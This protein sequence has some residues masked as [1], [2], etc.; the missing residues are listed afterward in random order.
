MSKR[1]VV[2]GA[3]GF[4]G[5]AVIDALNAAGM[6]PIGIDLAESGPDSIAFHGGIDLTDEHAITAALDAI[7]GSQ[8]IHGL[9]NVAGGFTWE[10]V[11]DSSAKSWEK[12]FRMNVLS[13]ANAS[14]A[15]LTHLK[16]GGSI[17]NIGAAAAAKAAAGMGVYTAAKSGVARLT[18]ALAE[19]CKDQ[20][21]RVNA[22][23]PS[24]I[25]TPANRNEMGD[26]DA[27]KWVKPAE[28]AA[29]ITFLL[30]DSASGVTGACIPVIGRV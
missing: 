29:V 6:E 22:V 16:E 17:V 14:R 25:D 15:A 5:R 12:M 9:V 21:I 8:G 24:I 4:L 26:A 23:L 3:A 30:T 2:T 11:A 13:A 19:E 1:I 18:E 20:G 28:L 7:A 10:T 27:H